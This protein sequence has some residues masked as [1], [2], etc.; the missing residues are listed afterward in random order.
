MGEGQGYLPTGRTGAGSHRETRHADR[1]TLCQPNHRKDAGP[2][3]DGLVPPPPG[4]SCPRAEPDLRPR[5][6]GHPGLVLVAELGGQEVGC[7]QPRFLLSAG[8]Q[9][10]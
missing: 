6:P 10:E 4:L 5:N 7:S 3:G 8:V 9:L 2:L 1:R